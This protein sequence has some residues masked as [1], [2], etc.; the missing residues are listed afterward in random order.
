M[1]L[2]HRVALDG[3]QLDSVDSRIMIQKVET[4]EGKENFNT[5]A[6]AVGSGSRVTGGHRDSL[7]ITVRFTIQLRKTEMA[8]REQVLER[9]NAWSYA[10]GWLTAAQKPGRRIRVYRAQAAAAGDP[11]DWTKVYSIVFR[12]CGVPYWQ[13]EAPQKVQRTGTAS[14]TMVLGV[15]GSEKTVVD[16][17]FVN[18]SGSRIDTFK[19]DTGESA[20]ELTSLG[21]MAGERLVIDH[22]DMGTMSYLRLRIHSGDE[23]RSVL[24][25]RTPGS[26][27]DLYV[28]PGSHQIQMTAG[29]R[30]RITISASGRFA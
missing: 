21:L 3:V 2:R 22:M 30:G 4:G 16:A 20:I 11:W 15:A 29:G 17:E 12:A 13:E 18:T 7:D 27:D 5:V 25:K 19:L 1:I 14:E 9:V 26:S 23:V 8:E 28:S 10:G 24:D 6:L